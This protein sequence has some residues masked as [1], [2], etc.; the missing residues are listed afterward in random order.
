MKAK[1]TKAVIPAA[2]LGTRF[3]PVTKTVSKEMI[4]IIDKPMIQFIV[5]EAI[6]SGIDDIVLVTSRHK[7]DLERYF[8]YNYELEDRLLKAG[9]TEMAQGI[10][11]IAE[12]CNIICVYQKEPAGLGHAVGCARS[13]V[14]DEPFAVLLGDDLIDSPVPCTRQLMNV[15]EATGM[16]VVGVMEVSPADVAKY[17]IVGGDPVDERTIRVRTMVEKPKPEDAPS[18][19]AIP[20]RYIVD[21][22]IF[23]LISKTRPGKNGEIQF[24]DSLLELARNRG[25]LAHRFIGN[26]YDTGDRLGYLDATLTFG[27]RRPELRGGILALLERHLRGAE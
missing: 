6:Q 19:L 4:P 23:D 21:S 20:G 12:C 8:D 18:R 2:G 1:I 10:R 11:K 17:G 16:S 14:G 25:L 7:E 9:K 22:S 15:Y 5:E 13:V 27:L 26:R 24:T 3:L